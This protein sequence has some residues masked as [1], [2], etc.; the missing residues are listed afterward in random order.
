MNS[1]RPHTVS[2][3]A[4]AMRYIV[5][6]ALATALVVGF[7]GTAQQ[8][9]AGSRSSEV[10]S[11]KA[12]K[13]ALKGLNKLEKQVYAS[14]SDA[15]L[16]ASLAQSYLS[17]GRFE[18]AVA[19]FN[20]T[21]ALGGADA[22]VGLGLALAYVGTGRN[23]EAL[24]VLDQYRDSIPASDLGLAMAL[25]GEPDRGAALLADA[26]RGGDNSAKVRQNLAYA[27]A[28]G[29][30]WREARTMAAQDVPADKL[31]ARLG[32]WAIQSNPEAY[33]IRVAGMIGA[34]V[35]G[36]TGQPA[37]LALNGAAPAPAMAAYE[38]AP[39]PLAA[40]TELPSLD[41]APGAVGQAT[42]AEAEPRP[43]EQAFAEPQAATAFES[44]AV[45]QQ[46][47]ATSSE[48]R[49]VRGRVAAASATPRAAG[50]ER[51]SSGGGSHL[52][53]LGSFSSPEGAQRAWKI[54]TARNPELKNRELVVTPAVVNGRKYWRVAAGGLNRSGA[55]GL[56][57][58]VKG[59]GG[60]CFAYAADRPIPG[61]LPARR[62]GAPMMA[63][64]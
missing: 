36:D 32:A 9:S 64:R 3:Q 59:R 51:P 62:A 23:A 10:A 52:V 14:P 20:D 1:T 31:D 13:A 33:R 46:I 60:A 27:Y 4:G 19:A 39:Q 8:A 56:C 45:V 48:A 53:Q 58:T 44:R 5:G 40:N 37:V 50:A 49:P 47:P 38:P 16:R 18:S 34:P 61:A 7:A 11:A 21:I 41:G 54:L 24:A 57:S 15:G 30:H 17:A 6:G 35:R 63:R 25:A 43:F 2:S 29:G 28:L 55:A 26:L 22:R 12:A 42:V